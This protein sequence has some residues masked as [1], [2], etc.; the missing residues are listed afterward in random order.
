MK[1]D[2]YSWQ[3]GDVEIEQPASKAVLTL[4]GRKYNDAHDERGRFASSDSSGTASDGEPVRVSKDIE[5]TQATGSTSSP[6]AAR[7]INFHRV[8]IA[9]RPQ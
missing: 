7:R 2:R 3:E 1:A 9:R 6:A 5:G 4:V 8:V